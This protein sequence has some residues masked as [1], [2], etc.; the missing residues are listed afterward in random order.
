MP[1]PL[2]IVPIL[3]ILTWAVSAHKDKLDNNISDI[4][5]YQLALP[6]VFSGG[7]DSPD[8]KESFL[9]DYRYIRDLLEKAYPGHE[10]LIVPDEY[11][12]TP[13]EGWDELPFKWRS[14]TIFKWVRHN[15][16]KRTLRSA[17]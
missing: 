1:W 9:K 5:S 15:I 11:D 12:I 4:A 7:H 10:F 6:T 8:S 2:I 13:K 14:H 3:W 16:Y 17:S